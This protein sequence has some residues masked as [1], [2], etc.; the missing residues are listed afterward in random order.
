MRNGRGAYFAEP[1]PLSDVPYIVAAELDGQA[2]DSRIFLAAPVSLEDVER[3]LDAQVVSEHVMAWDDAAEMVRAVRRTRLGAL[4]LREAPWRETDPARATA[5]LLDVVRRRGLDALPWERAS[6]QLRDR[7]RFAHALDASWPDASDAALLATLDH[8]LAPALHG[9][10]R[11]EDVRRVA[12]GAALA[13]LMTWQQR[14]A[15]DELAP[16]HWTVPTGSRIAIDYA[17]PAAPAAAV[18]LQELFGLA[19][20]PRVGGGRVPLTLQLLSPAQRP[21]QVTRDLAGFWR[22]SYF[23]VRKELRGRYPKHYWPDDP[24]QAE[25]TRRVRRKG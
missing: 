15:L 23:D 21:V 17:D 20:T 16:T 22:S 6:T 8:W 1:Q 9:A 10:R 11:W 2:R 5:V 7:L 19:E 12:L 3:Q 4:V 14:A 25:P 18:R 13:D 24:L